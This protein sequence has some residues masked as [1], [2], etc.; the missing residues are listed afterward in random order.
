[1]SLLISI[2]AV[3]FGLVF[4]SF[5]NVCVSRLPRHQSVVQPRS[6]CPECQTPILNRDNVPVIGWL[7]L[8]GRC[9]SCGVQIPA[10]YPLIELATAALFLLCS[11]VF[12]GFPIVAACILCWLL[13]GLAASDA[14][15][16]RLPDALTLP[17]IA[18]GILVSG[19]GG[20]SGQKPAFYWESAGFALL[21]ATVA[22]GLILLL[23]ALYW[24]A[25]RR[26]GVGLGDAKLL[27]MIAAWLGPWQTG[28]TLFL[29]VICAA[30]YGMLLM[31][32]ER[33][34]PS[35][36]NKRT[37]RIPLGAFL[38]AAGI[39]CLF[40]GDGLLHWYLGLLT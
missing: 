21:W 6:R 13:L 33:S 28:T 17:G 32:A 8:R 12:T 4:G 10:R 11:L 7:L 15:T 2:F 20:M 30:L 27:A 34:E 16:F 5:L 29:A 38:S 9:R 24:L 3:L 1:M 25:R 40:K 18:L 35:A 14:E 36:K 19:F 22:A 39:F 31:V 37:A 23:R 26:E